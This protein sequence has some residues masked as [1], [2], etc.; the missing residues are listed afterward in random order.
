MV[1]MDDLGANRPKRIRKSIEQHDCELIYLP[2]YSP[3]YNPIEEAFAKIKNLLS[4][5]PR[6]GA[7]RLWWKR[8]RNGPVDD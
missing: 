5:R 6:P 3:E 1:V 8:D 4:A 2:A 7:K